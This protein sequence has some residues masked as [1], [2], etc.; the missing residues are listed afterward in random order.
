MNNH[1]SVNTLICGKLAQETIIN[2]KGEYFVD[3]MGGNLL[4]TAYSYNLWKQGA[5]LAAKI[6]ENYSEKWLEDIEANHFNT[7]GIKRLPLNLDQRAFYAFIS[8][9]EYRTDNPQRYFAELKLPFPKS[10]LGYNPQPVTLDN[11]KSGT[12]ISLRS[13][14]IPPDLL[15]CNFLYLCPLDYFT[16]N[17]IPPAFRINHTCEI[18]I[19]PPVSYMH[20]SFYYD[21]PAIFRGSTA[22]I[23]T[24]NRAESLFLGRTKD[25]WEMMET[26]ASFGVELV[27][28]T[29]GSEGQYLYDHQGK[30]KYHIPAYPV[31]PIDTI[32]ANDAFGGGFL[33]GY[34]IHFDPVMAALMGNISASI[35][36]EGS[37]PN[38]LLQALPD[39]AKARLEHIQ[40]Q[41]EEC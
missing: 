23:T 36:V 26:I 11:R 34:L 2:L 31:K 18:I 38:Q 5:G 39:L 12:E 9:D 40:D 17:L 8:E 15:Y 29:A 25:I 33:A 24:I 28:I 27:V 41:V 6:G 32:H 13:D 35:K 10:L 16:H 30:K 1:L 22:I 14:D 19:N 20:S 37:T 21:I 4:Y 7:L 3:K